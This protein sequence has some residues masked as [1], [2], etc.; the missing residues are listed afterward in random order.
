MLGQSKHEMKYKQVG[1]PY[2]AICN[3]AAYH[4]I[5]NN[6]A[7][8]HSN[9]LVEQNS[10]SM[11]RTHART[12][13]CSLARTQLCTCARPYK[14]PHSSPPHSLPSLPST[15]YVVPGGANTTDSSLDKPDPLSSAL[16]FP[17]QPPAP[18]S[19]VC[20]PSL[21]ALSPPLSLPRSLSLAAALC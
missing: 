15:R 19:P 21:H 17:T 9:I 6:D 8:M 10:K 5:C 2:H 18:P 12:H 20:P 11:T 3:N 14:H 1:A 16:P 7:M 13:A 4:A